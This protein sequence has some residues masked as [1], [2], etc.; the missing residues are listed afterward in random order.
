[1]LSRGGESAAWAERGRSLEDTAA[2]LCRD[3]SLAVMAVRPAAMTR[4]VFS[5]Y[6]NFAECSGSD[7]APEKWR[8][9]GQEDQ[10][11]ALRHLRALVDSVQAEVSPSQEDLIRYLRTHLVFPI[12]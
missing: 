4:G 12:V 6:H 10:T 7:G 9:G 11:K 3:I 8:G 5:R 2:G 1:M